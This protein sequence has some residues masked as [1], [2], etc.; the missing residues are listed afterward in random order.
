MSEHSHPQDENSPTAPETPVDAGSQALAEAL[1]SSFAVVKI[2]MVALVLVFL[3]S[4]FFQV[5]PQER[6]MILR[7][8]K[9]VGEGANALLGPGLHFGCPPPIDEIQKVSI[10]GIQQV[11][12]TV[13]WYA[14]TPEAELTGNEPFPGPSL[15]PAIDGYT[16][17]ADGNIIH[18]RATLYYHIEDPI[19]YT[20]DFVN[21]PQVVQDALD[22]ALVYASAHFK[23]D[24]IL[25]RDKFG[26][27][28]A[29]RNRATELLEKEKVGVVV[30]RCDVQ[31]KWPRQQKVSDAFANVLNA[32]INRSKLLNEA[33][34]H[35]NQVLSKAG[36]DSASLTNTAETERA[37]TVNNAASQAKWFADL[38]PKY[39]ANPTLFEQQRL[40]ET[41]SRVLTN[42]NEK[43]Y[44]SGRA[45]GKSRELRLLLSREAPK[46]MTVNT[47]Q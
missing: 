16:L 20:F 42:V 24:D 4:G 15:N 5:G 9:P 26:F 8:G 28:E 38:L 46:A 11:R 47:N 13:G 37:Q 30:D 23:V 25:T 45:D 21:A 31:S 43:I 19:R 14:T 35:E 18:T 44:L 36:A 12:S 3:G 7:F 10:T 1:R 2:V 40:N 6:A 34:S 32:E 27:Q 29:V 22:N 41:M 17:S 33:R 39:E